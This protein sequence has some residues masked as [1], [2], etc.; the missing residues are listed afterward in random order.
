ML[1]AINTFLNRY[2]FLKIP[3]A[4]LKNGFDR[5]LKQNSGNNF[6]DNPPPKKKFQLPKTNFFL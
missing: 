4:V 2:A 3:M 1:H 5:K 6:M